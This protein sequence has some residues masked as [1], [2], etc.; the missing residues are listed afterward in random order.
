MADH[1]VIDLDVAI[2][3]G[4]AAGLWLLDALL[5]KGYETLLLEAHTLGSGQTVASQG[6]IHGGLKYTLKG[7]FTASANA[8]KEMPLIWREC[9]QGQRRPNLSNTRLRSG[10]CYLW[11]NESVR[12][13]V[14]MLGAKSLLRV[15]PVALTQPDWPAALASCGGEVYRLDEQ[16]IDP[17][18]FITDLAAQH[19]GRILHVD[20]TPPDASL[21][22]LAGAGQVQSIH[23]TAPP[24]VDLGDG[25]GA[26]LVLRPRV[27]VFTAGRGNAALREHAGLS[28]QSMQR[29]PLHMVVVRSASGVPDAQLPQLHGHCTDGNRT[30]V[31][32]TSDVAATGRVVWQVGGQVAEDGVNRSPEQL[33]AHAKAELAQA[34]GRDD[35]FE[36]AQWSTYRVDRAEAATRQNTRPDHPV[37]MHEGNVISAWPTK[38]ALVPDMVARVVDCLDQPAELDCLDGIEPLTSWPRPAVAAPPWETNTPWYD[39]V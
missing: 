9:L 12:S 28:V 25:V 29:R 4:G 18:S 15:K 11:R 38:L 20:P 31:T 7:L 26:A 13:R 34:L 27:V 8:I 6:I 32:I 24:E 3:G 16:V 35:L 21:F 19:A 5:A 14:G 23:V 1:D 10:Y 22:Q 33:V 37:V 30:R 36:S 17:S 2:L 39:D